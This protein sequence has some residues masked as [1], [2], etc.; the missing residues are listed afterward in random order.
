V[1]DFTLLYVEDDEAILAV[2]EPMLTKAVDNLYLAR[3]GEEGL[4]LFQAHKEN[5]DLIITDIT[6]PEMD[7]LEMSE[8]IREIK[9]RVPIVVTTAL[10]D[11]SLLIRA[12]NIGIDHYLIKPIRFNQIREYITKYKD[13]KQERL[14]FKKS[15]H[16]LEEYKSIVDETTIVSKTDLSGRITYA[17]KSFCDISGYTQ[18]ELLGKPHSIVRHPDMEADV[19]KT[20]WDTI[21]AGEVWRGVVLN[22]AKDGHGYHLDA[23]IFPM[24]DEAGTIIEYMSIRHDVTQQEEY[25]KLL[26]VKLDNQNQSL[27]ESVHAAKEYEKAIDASTL[28][29]RTDPDGVIIYAN[30][31][32]C[33]VTGYSMLELLSTEF[34]SLRHPDT[35]H[36]YFKELWDTIKAGKIW[37]NYLKNR[38]KSGKTLHFYITVTPITNKAGEIV[39]FLATY[40]DISEIITVNEEIEATQH[41][42]V[43]R[44]GAIG[45]SRSKE[46]GNHVKRVAEYSYHLAKL[47]GLNEEEATLLKSASPMH[48]IGKVGI[49]DA[50]LNKPGRLTPE[51]FDVMKEHAEIGYNVLRGSMRPV[52]NTAA[53]VA[54]EHHEKWDGSGYPRGLK[55]ERIHIYGRITA[56]AD[57]FD[58]LGSDRPYKKAW[59]LDRILDLIR[60]GRGTHFD[61][62]LV[63]LFL[64]HLN[65][66]L[67]IRERLADT[68]QG[69]A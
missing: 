29:V 52:L 43:H 36:E 63:D 28:L 38:A 39:E 31:T 58:A 53:I 64:E 25:K 8:A 9:S 17:N 1:V 55:S 19:F 44:M 4:A 50:I 24:R 7:G 45:E 40:Q 69:N 13:R 61:P 46:T 41:E 12:I 42:I 33:E 10:D 59:E 23:A 67:E 66:F 51:E 48:D 3:N 15:Q 49:P 16:F 60:E 47:Y 34:E 30:D 11:S 21:K 37:H 26:H 2:L 65:L 6:M 35:T 5:I 68:F 62:K 20:M 54:Y 57:V 27:G 32:F 18:E 56:L 22:R 14:A